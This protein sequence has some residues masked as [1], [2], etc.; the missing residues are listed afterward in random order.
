MDSLRGRW[1]IEREIG[2]MESDP[3]GEVIPCRKGQM[4]VLCLGNEP[5]LAISVDK[6]VPNSRYGEFR[7]LIEGG[8]I[9]VMANTDR[10]FDASVTN[11]RYADQVLQ[12]MGGYSREYAH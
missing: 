1:H 4:W 3:L 12:T 11:I 9:K 6:T 2:A 8:Q 5:S 10:G 7:G